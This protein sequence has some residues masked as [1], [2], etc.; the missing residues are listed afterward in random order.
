LTFI[1]EMRYIK[2]KHI[3]LDVY[4]FWIEGKGFYNHVDLSLIGEGKSRPLG[5]FSSAITLNLASCDVHV[6]NNTMF[7]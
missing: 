4:H 7:F 1:P 3:H 5:C 2:L 6:V